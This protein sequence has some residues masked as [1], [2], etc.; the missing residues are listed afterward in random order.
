MGLFL[1]YSHDKKKKGT[2]MK[3]LK[4][5]LPLLLTIITLAI[6]NPIETQ[7]STTQ[8]NFTRFTN[9]LF[10]IDSSTNI[11]L[12]NGV[13]RTDKLPIQNNSIIFNNTNFGIILFWNNNTFLGY[14][15]RSG[16]TDWSP[17][18]FLLGN[19]TAFSIPN[20]A[21]HFALQSVSSKV[22]LSNL[23]VSYSNPTPITPLSV[24]LPPT[25]FIYLEPYGLSY[26]GYD[27]WRIAQ[28]HIPNINTL[29][30]ALLW[31]TNSFVDIDN[32]QFT[33]PADGLYQGTGVPGTIQ[34]HQIGQL[35][36]NTTYYYRTY[37][38]ING[39]YY[40]SSTGSVTTPNITN[41]T[42]PTPT[43]SIT[44]NLAAT[45]TFPAVTQGNIGQINDRGWLW[46][47]DGTTPTL[48][49]TLSRSPYATS[50]GNNNQYQIFPV[51]D[52]STTYKYRQ[53]VRDGINANSTTYYSEVLT[54]TTPNQ[55]FNVE[56]R[57]HDETLISTVTVEQ[58]ESVTNLPPNPI[59]TGFTFNSWQPPVTNIQGNLVT[60]AIY[61]QNSYL[62]TFLSSGVL[63]GQQNVLHGSGLDTTNIPIPTLQG[64]IFQHYT[65][66]DNVYNINNS[67]IFPMELIA[68]FE[69]IPT[70]TITWRDP[71]FNV[72]KV[73]T[74][75]S[76]LT[77]TPPNYVSNSG[78]TLVGWTPDITQPVTQNIQYIAIVQEVTTSGITPIPIDYNPITDLFGGVIGASVGAIMTLGTIELYGITLNSLIFLFISMTVGLWILKAIRG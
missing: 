14:F 2:H 34:E 42:I 38:E 23:S 32:Y 43:Y 53:Y 20:N 52:Y 61:D 51:L 33:S 55:T 73:E 59:R 63:V 77:G 18:A 68:V 74:V 57:D 12:S 44:P 41:H 47:D 22:S 37:V 58:G 1:I 78:F 25:P 31:S 75:N 40:Y 11:I 62:V 48:T 24:S 39:N 4:Y 26:N 69:P 36:P 27:L 71:A 13:E 17:N 65:L 46:T 45:I 7:A 28:V 35:T 64:F 67:V 15:E 49:N 16:H 76:G 19:Y 3:Q 70:F 56:F 6:Y 66:F 72:L 21:T 8:Y 5:I 50:I 30:S 60:Y 54:F 10:T 29:T 9:S